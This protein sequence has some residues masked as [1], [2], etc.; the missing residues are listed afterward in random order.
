MDNEVT[1]VATEAAIEPTHTGDVVETS[2]PGLDKV[3][4][5]AQRLRSERNK[6]REE[7]EVIKGRLTEIE[8]TKERQMQEETQRMIE[9]LNAERDALRSELNRTKD[10]ATLG[11]KVRDPE[12]ALKLLEADHR[13]DD[14][15]ILVDK[16]L[17]RYPFLAT[18]AGP[19]SV[20]GGGGANRSGDVMTLEKAMA[21]G[22][23][24]LIA[25]AMNALNKRR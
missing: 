25:E 4:R 11:G 14:G 5:E 12:A 16:L 21:T 9:Q 17:E 19:S 22:D 24:K 20:P 8:S 2:V 23:Y 10:M 18:E 1:Q 13:A 7:L 3:K 15:S 6:A